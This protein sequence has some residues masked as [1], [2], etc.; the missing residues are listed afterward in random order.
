MIAAAVCV[1]APGLV[2]R[3]GAD[4]P[5]ILLAGAFVGLNG[6]PVIWAALGNERLGLRLTVTFAIVSV[7]L[8]NL[9]LG[10]RMSDGG[11][12]S[13]S[14]F[15]R[16]FGVLPLVFLVAQS[17]LWIMRAAFG[18]RIIRTE[19][20]PFELSGRNRQFGIRELL[21]VTAVV[22]IALAVARWALPG[23]GVR[24]QWTGLIWPLVVTFFWSLFIAPPCV[25]FMFRT[26]DLLAVGVM[27]SLHASFVILS[28]SGIAMMASGGPWGG[29]LL[30]PIGC[31][32]AGVFAVLWG[33]LAVLRRLGFSL[34][35]GNRPL[36]MSKS[37]PVE[38][39]AQ[40]GDEGYNTTASQQ[41]ACH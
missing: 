31:F 29:E 1:I 23:D 4:T 16:V 17:P 13:I 33:S 38:H 6:A 36:D 14:D 34:L 7:F 5:A 37:S 41:H 10:F 32:H 3:F 24:T 11:Q 26:T 12:P 35:V 9:L 30:L 21:I 25:W 27:V 28:A 20:E 22:A 19:M 39:S 40:T 2:V 15:R 18:W 8:F